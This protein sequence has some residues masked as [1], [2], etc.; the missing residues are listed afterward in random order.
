MKR[1]LVVLFTILVLSVPSIVVAHSL[2]WTAVT[3]NT[4]GT[5][6]TDLAGYNAYDVTGTRTKINTAT[7]PTTACVSGVCKFVIPIHPV[8]GRSYVL[9]AVDTDI[10][11]SAD[12]NTATY[13]AIPS[14]P[15]GAVIVI[16]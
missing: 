2:Q 8:E 5:T 14:A 1:L 11:E 4:D 9:T 12:S 15:G 16:Q 10:Q 6:I 13:K 3:T 7:I